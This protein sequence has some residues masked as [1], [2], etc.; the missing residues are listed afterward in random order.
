V[1]AALKKLGVKARDAVLIGDTPYDVE[2]ARAAGVASIAFRC[3]EWDD[4]ALEGAIALYDDP[5]DLMRNLD[6]SPLGIALRKV[7]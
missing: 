4:H 3:G 5:W 6:S 1:R 7:G 2:A